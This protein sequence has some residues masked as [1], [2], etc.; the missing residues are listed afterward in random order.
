LSAE[1]WLPWLLV[2]RGVAG[3]FDTLFN[4]ELLVGRPPRPDAHAEIG[5]HRIREGIYGLLF[6]GLAWFAS[7]PWGGPCGISSRG[8]G[9]AARAAWRPRSGMVKRTHR[10]ARARL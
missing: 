9:C 6:I 8:A 3:G 7:L 2:A 5:L 1:E 4:H 10:R